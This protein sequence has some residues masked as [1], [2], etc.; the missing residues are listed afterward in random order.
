MKDKPESECKK[1]NFIVIDKIQI[2]S[3]RRYILLCVDCGKIYEREPEKN[4][5]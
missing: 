3:L 1:H 2:G 4:E 5:R